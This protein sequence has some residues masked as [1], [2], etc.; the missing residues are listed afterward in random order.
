MFG[1]HARGRLPLAAMVALAMLAMAQGIIGRAPASLPPL[2][3]ADHLAIQALYN[4]TLHEAGVATGLRHWLTNL[5]VEPAPGGASGEA[6]GWA[7]IVRSQGTATSAAVLYRDRLV[8]GSAGWRVDVR[9]EFSG[10]VMPLRDHLLPPSNEG[11]KAFTAR[12]FAEVKRLVTRYNL[13]YDNAGPFD[14]G[15]LSSLSFTLDAMFERPGGAT[16]IGRDGAI[17][18]ARE[19]QTKPGLHHWDTNFLIDVSPSGEVTSVNYD[20]QFN[21]SGSTGEVVNL[22]SAGL[23][24]HRFTRTPEGWLIKYR[25]YDSPAAVP[26]MAWPEPAYGLTARGVAADPAAPRVRG[27][28]SGGDYVEIDQLYA[29]ANFA[30]DTGMENGAAFARMFTT[31]GSLVRSGVVTTGH[32][33]L[34]A[35]AAPSATA[36]AVHTWMSNLAIEPSRDGATGRVYALDFTS[37]AAKP[38][39]DSGRLDDVLVKTREGWRFKT[40]VYVSEIA[41]VPASAAAASFGATAR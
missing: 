13:G 21:V 34:A 4:R 11:S 7:Y 36:P 8:R 2:T 5:V 39:N 28:L 3:A 17:A 35:L 27:T 40:R 24:F 25:R 9:E 15:V 38:I 23:L 1:I 18:Q 37:G 19:F 20:M 10:T 30:F 14:S 26:K 29:R 6:L 22:R 12:D 31:D 32:A 41:A 16:R 33:A